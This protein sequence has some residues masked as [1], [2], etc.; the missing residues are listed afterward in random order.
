MTPAIPPVGVEPRGMY[1]LK[2]RGRRLYPCVSRFVASVEAPDLFVMALLTRF[3]GL[4]PRLFA[5][6]SEAKPRRPQLRGAEGSYRQS[7]R[8]G[9]ARIGRP[10]QFHPLIDFRGFEEGTDEKGED[11][12][13]VVEG[14]GAC[15]VDDEGP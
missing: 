14:L 1:T 10:A 3:A 13:A 11:L 7:R 15:P 4:F 2:R 9:D 8:Q 12:T 5:E 6:T